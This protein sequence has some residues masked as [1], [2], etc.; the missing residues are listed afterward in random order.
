MFCN[1]T[2]FLSIGAILLALGGIHV[3]AQGAQAQDKA[4]GKETGHE[5]ELQM[6]DMARAQLGQGSPLLQS[7]LCYEIATGYVQVD[8]TKAIAELK[9]CFRYTLAID[10]ADRESRTGFQLRILN[11]LYNLDPSGA[12]EILPGA[13][14]RVRSM[15]QSQIIDKLTAAGKL[16]EAFTQLTALSYR[17]EFPY[18]AAGRLMLE[19]PANRDQDRR[20]FLS[21]P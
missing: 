19:L 21:P 3:T 11:A 8:R 4:A 17:P 12:K 14:P 20:T 1:K 2:S 18:P 9:Q 13:E 6:L 15:I 10:D 5:P 16:D 7:F